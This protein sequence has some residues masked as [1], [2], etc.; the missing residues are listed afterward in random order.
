MGRTATLVAVLGAVVVTSAATAGTGATPVLYEITVEAR[1]T[2]SWTA[3]GGA[4]CVAGAGGYVGASLATQR[5]VRVLVSRSATGKPTFR[6]PAGKALVVPL[7][8]YITAA[9]RSGCRPD[10]TG[11][12]Q[13]GIPPGAVLRLGSLPSNKSVIP[14][15]IEGVRYKPLRG[16][17]FLGDWLDFNRMPGW[18]AYASARIP[19]GYTTKVR[20]QL[21]ASI[22][23]ITGKLS[24]VNGT[25][26]GKV[27][28]TVYF[29]KVNA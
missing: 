11:C 20:W 18:K 8:G 17:C 21:D 25:G 5:G 9:D 3:S 16:Q 22:P 29:R 14:T 24:S 28:V 6:S 4:P 1:S 13:R 12:A 27:T 7:Y 26:A 10:N 2:Y 15:I 23:S 19:A